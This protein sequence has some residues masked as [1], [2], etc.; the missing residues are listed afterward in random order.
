MDKLALLISAI[1]PMPMLY[2]LDLWMSFWR[3]EMVI[4]QLTLVPMDAMAIITRPRG[5]V[6]MAFQPQAPWVHHHQQVQVL[7]MDAKC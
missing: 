3:K 4:Q 1:R 2:L 7:I 5:I 6:Q